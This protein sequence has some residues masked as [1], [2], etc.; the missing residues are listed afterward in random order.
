MN[1]SPAVPA[2]RTVATLAG[3]VSRRREGAGRGTRGRWWLSDVGEE[4]RSVET[5]TVGSVVE[6][7]S[8]TMAERGSG[9][10]D[11]GGRGGKA[12]VTGRAKR[13]WR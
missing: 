3:A 13:R 12:A 10:D 11:L 4:F 5:L 6:S 7:G 2:R 8:G 9:C 1:R